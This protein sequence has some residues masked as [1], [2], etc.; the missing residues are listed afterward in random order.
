MFVIRAVARIL[1]TSC[2]I[3]EYICHIY[4]PLYNSSALFLFSI[5]YY[6]CEEIELIKKPNLVLL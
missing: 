3:S 2:R 1:I 5:I 6:K 4:L